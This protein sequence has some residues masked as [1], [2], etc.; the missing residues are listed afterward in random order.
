M[1]GFQGNSWIRLDQGD[2]DRS[3]CGVPPCQLNRE[4]WEDEAEVAPICE[5]SRTKEGG[6]KPSVCEHPLRNRLR[7]GA[8]PRSS[9][10]VQPVD[11]RPIE[12]LCPEF[13]PIQDSTSGA[14]QTAFTVAMQVLGSLRTA[15]T[16]EKGRFSCLRLMSDA[17]RRKGTTFQPASCRKRLFHRL[18]HDMGT[19]TIS[20]YP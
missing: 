16:I 12:V 2:E 11:R 20:L 15:E 9:Q 18:G 13:D 4:R 14:L 8:L 6:T 1:E 5:V 7:D 3:K 10:P 17:G 19:L